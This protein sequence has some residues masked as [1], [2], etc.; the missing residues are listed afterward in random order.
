MKKAFF[1][2][3]VI[4]FFL[5]TAAVLPV[6]AQSPPTAPIISISPVIFD[7]SLSPGESQEFFVSVTNR[8]ERPVK[9]KPEVL[10][11]ST[12]DLTGQIKIDSLGESLF[13]LGDWL[14]FVGGAFELKAGESRNFRFRLTPPQEAPV[15]GHYAVLSFSTINEEKTRDT[16]VSLSGR[17]GALL[18]LTV[19]GEIVRSSR[20]AGFFIPAVFFKNKAPVAVQIKNE[21]TTH[22]SYRGEVKIFDFLG[23]KVG[24][25]PLPRHIILPQKSRILKLNWDNPWRPGLFRAELKAY[26]LE[27]KELEAKTSFWHFPL[28]PIVFLL[29]VVLLLIL[30]GF[31]L[32]L[33]LGKR[34]SPQ[35]APKSL[36]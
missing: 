6:K 15:G 34:L 13:S 7:Y 8:G 25:L 5:Q 2:L 31:K 21:G 32:G 22:E 27:G 18:L 24:E 11:F 28:A 36:T 4:F 12:V 19:Q 23:R 20:I 10:P 3:I 16:N 9:L 1:R 26:S 33:K 30:G 17:V 14:E 29:I 35:S